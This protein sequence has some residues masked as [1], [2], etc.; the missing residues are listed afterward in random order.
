MGDGYRGPKLWEW[1]GTYV[2]YSGYQKTRLKR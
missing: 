1:F 2:G